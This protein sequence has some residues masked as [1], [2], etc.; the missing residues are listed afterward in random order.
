MLNLSTKYV[1]E[2]FGGG[3]AR[4]HPWLRAWSTSS[5]RRA[6]GI[7]ARMT[8]DAFLLRHNRSLSL[9]SLR[10]PVAVIHPGSDVD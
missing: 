6:N 9:V 8:F 2:N 5:R 1:F 10:S 4:L 3:N 7:V